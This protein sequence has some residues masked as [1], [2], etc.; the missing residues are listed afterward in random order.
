MIF[1]D[2]F[3]ISI[4]SLVCVSGLAEN[5][6]KLLHEWKISENIN[7]EITCS[8]ND[9]DN[10]LTTTILETPDNSVLCVN[11][12]GKESEKISQKQ[13]NFNYNG[14]LQ[15]GSKYLIE[16][17]IKGSVRGKVLINCI[18]A[19]PPWSS[20]GRGALR[21]LAVE[22]EWKTI[23]L[24]FSPSR[25]WTG[26]M[27]I[28]M[29]CV[30]KFP[31]NEKLYIR[32]VKMFQTQGYLPYALNKK[33]TLFAPVD[34][35]K[36][37]LVNLDK[38]P[39]S[40][41][42]IQENTIKGQNINIAE[43]AVELTQFG[44]A[45]KAKKAAVL[46]NEFDCSEAGTMQL[47]ASADWWFEFYINGK[48]VFST[49]ESGGNYSSKF[50]PEDHVFNIPIK[51]GKNLVAVKVLS[52][53]GGWKFACG[54]VKFIKHVAGEVFA[55]KDGDGWKAVN[56]KGEWNPS[57]ARPI[58][59][60][61]IMVKPGTALDLSRFCDAPSGKYG[62]VIINSK[63][64]LAF[65]QHPDKP[66]KFRSFNKGL[67]WTSNFYKMTKEE[68]EEFAHAIALRGFNMVRFGPGNALMGFGG[69]PPAVK[70]RKSF[71]DATIPQKPEEMKL[72]KAFLDRLDYFVFCLKKHGIYID[73][74]LGA[75]TDAYPSG[76]IMGMRTANYCK[77]LIYFSDDLKRNWV[78]GTTFLLNH[79][80]PYTGQS[81]L[82]ENIIANITFMNEQDTRSSFL[83]VFTPY[84]RNYLKEKYKDINKL[85]TAWGCTYKSFDD[86]PAI[87]NKQLHTGSPM[88]I[89]A[90]HFLEKNMC[91]LTGFFYHELRKI[92]YKGPFSLWDMYMRLVEIPPR[93][94][95]SLV[96]M[97]SYHDHV[98]VKKHSGSYKQ[99]N[100]AY[101]WWKNTERN[102]QQVSSITNNT[103]SY[104]RRVAATRFLDRPF[105]INEF[106]HG[107]YNQYHHEQG[108]VFGCY[109][110]LQGWDS[111]GTHSDVVTLYHTA[112]P[113]FS[114]AVDPV[115]R[116][117]DFLATFAW[118]R[119]DV[120][121]AKHSVD[122]AITPEMVYSKNALDAIGSEYSK[123]ALITKIGNSYPIKPL[124]PT[125][126]YK[127]DLTI[128]PKE[129]A[130]TAGS[131]FFVVTKDVLDQGKTTQKIVE[132]LRSKNIIPS[133]NSTDSLKGIYQS[134]TGEIVTDVK[135]GTMRV[136]SPKLE[137]VI[138]KADKQVNLDKLSV[139]A[140]STPACVT[141][142]SL[143]DNKTVGDSSK[144][145]L[146]FSTHAVGANTVFASSKMNRVLEA[147]TF[148]M[149]MKTGKLS[150]SIQTANQKVPQVYALNMDG[151]R[152]E[153]IKGKL[154]DGKLNISIDT[155]KLKYATPYFE[156]V[157]E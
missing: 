64:K 93:G 67:G 35:T 21:T 43:K 125:A 45:V 106:S 108:L 59:I 34:A 66:V 109:A 101:P 149:L 76:Q 4:L 95:V 107:A 8:N 97:H 48:K 26:P 94:M 137:G 16:L 60:D 133:S 116:A 132:K 128:Q 58:K 118:F 131:E 157:F 55:V 1:R 52:G 72:D 130:W 91:D 15:A 32:S 139:N 114:S 103:V 136:V 100:L 127:A 85:S 90:V 24:E 104:F 120:Q 78:A 18:L 25:T 84:W 83:P 122:Y 145:L 113:M 73:L 3:C 19:A 154:V 150:V 75:W 135:K 147:G 155:S 124:E 74:M 40:L 88:A 7:K 89:D 148:P 50:V 81:L 14:T 38:I 126:K 11:I 12:N 92:G 96:S 27:R 33:W 105:I 10:P 117:S 111:L 156:V 146:V 9:K 151:T 31:A 20:L 29:I 153:T 13:I 53:S 82:N 54:K 99:K 119:G 121:T 51:K 49:V 42:G 140:C 70:D 80:N 134:E 46:F 41:P 123:I 44:G 65:G 115:S 68:L 138:I 47:G 141:V 39:E 69:L 144:L 56:M 142:L 152:A 36:I 143:D 87:T 23:K 77:S 86:I 5:N 110:A 98:G 28:P 6:T 79:V 22:T 112:A 63:G 57:G 129:F 71:T 30:G 37:N 2:I 62:P 17:D 61:E 102:F